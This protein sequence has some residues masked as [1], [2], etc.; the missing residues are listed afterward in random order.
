[1]IAVHHLLPSYLDSRLNGISLFEE[2]LFLFRLLD[3]INLRNIYFVHVP[4]FQAEM[5]FD[6]INRFVG[7]STCQNNRTVLRS[8]ELLVEIPHLLYRQTIEILNSAEI[9]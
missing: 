7:Y 6:Q 8:V 9:P 1:M 3:C 4:V 5:L 2:E